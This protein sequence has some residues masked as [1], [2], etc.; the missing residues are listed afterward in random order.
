MNISLR[1]LSNAQ[2]YQIIFDN[3]IQLKQNECRSITVK[4]YL[5]TNEI[6]Q[7]ELPR[8]AKIRSIWIERTLCNQEGL[9]L[10]RDKNIIIFL[11][12]IIRQSGTLIVNIPVSED[13][14][15]ETQSHDRELI[16]CWSTTIEVYCSKSKSAQRELRFYHYSNKPD[17]CERILQDIKN[18]KIAKDCILIDEEGQLV[19]SQ[20]I[21]EAKAPLFKIYLISIHGNYNNLEIYQ[22]LTLINFAGIENFT[23]RITGSVI[24]AMEEDFM[25]KFT[26]I[27]SSPLEVRVSEFSRLLINK[28]KS[29]WDR[30]VDE[31][32]SRLEKLNQCYIPTDSLN[33]HARR[34]IIDQIILSVASF[35][36]I[37]FFVEENIRPQL[38]PNQIGWGKLDYRFTDA[39]TKIIL[40]SEDEVVK[41]PADYDALREEI[42]GSTEASSKGEGHE[43]VHLSTVEAKQTFEDKGLAQICAQLHDIAKND[44]L[45]SVSGV[46]CTGTT[47][48]Y[49]LLQEDP[50]DHGKM[51]LTYEGG[52]TLSI[53]RSSTPPTASTA[54]KRRP[55]A[56]NESAHV[57]KIQVESVMA[58]AA[59]MRYRA[60]TKAPFQG[61]HDYSILYFSFSYHEIR[62]LRKVAILCCLLI[63]PS[64]FT[65]QSKAYH[66]ASPTQ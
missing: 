23:K 15:Y 6:F 53:I 54:Q 10:F 48:K 39:I 32:H 16:F 61:I 17:S 22:L 40:E 57:D 33:E 9:D 7:Y 1:S 51:S 25:K 63:E 18:H 41:I 11:H 12:S 35:L 13:E 64:S 58:F 66:F 50:S 62:Y 46:L 45:S 60:T 30:L 20:S 24:T 21:I 36:D 5:S 8:P 2:K 31:T 44:S 14:E 49:Y 37:T 42:E 28:R 38:V 29:E 55:S 65:F 56:I 3:S 59:T 34:M 19:T 43:F 4:F 52:R 47:W 27:Q 26:N